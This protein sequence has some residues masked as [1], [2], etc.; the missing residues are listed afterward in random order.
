MLRLLLHCTALER[1]FDFILHQVNTFIEYHS[2]PVLLN[3]ERILDTQYNS[4][5]PLIW[6]S[7]QVSF[8][9]NCEEPWPGIILRRH[10]ASP[11]RGHHAPSF[12]DT[13]QLRKKKKTCA[14]ALRCSV[15]L[16]PSAHSIALSCC[17]KG[18]ASWKLQ[19]HYNI[20]L[21]IS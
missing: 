13:H 5:Y 8:F 1:H 17:G 11:R 4:V 19:S 2:M 7:R 9:Q 16:S 15:S 12:E 10:S 18:A 6:R 21:V 20:R 14:R 3:T